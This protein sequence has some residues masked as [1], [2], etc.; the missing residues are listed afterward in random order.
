[1]KAARVFQFI[2]L[3]VVVA[4]L[5]WVYSANQ[6]YVNLPGLVD[7]PAGV[8]VALALLVG[9]LIA[10]LPS[11]FALWR[12]RREITKLRSRLAELEPSGVERVR[13]TRDPVIPDR[14]AYPVTP[15]PDYENL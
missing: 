15:G 7:L 2:L 12:R 1:M 14:E 8:V 3:V 5:W 9:W 11:R 10:W 6:T 4:Y 13:T